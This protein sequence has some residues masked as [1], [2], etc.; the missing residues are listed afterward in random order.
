MRKTKDGH[1][2]RVMN[3]KIS[4]LTKFLD[5]KKRLFPDKTEKPKEKPVQKEDIPG[6]AVGQ[7]GV[8]MAPN[9]GPKLKAID[10]TDKRYRKDKTPVV[11]KRF[12]THVK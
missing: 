10:V 8:D 2:Q 9:M 5:R 7:G 3:T 12:R 4:Q 6:N 1:N 11:L